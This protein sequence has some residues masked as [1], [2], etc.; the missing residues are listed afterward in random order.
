MRYNHD[1]QPLYSMCT[2]PS[3]RRAG[4]N[5]RSPQTLL[6]DVRNLGRTSAVFLLVVRDTSSQYPAK[7]PDTELKS[8][9]D[10]VIISTQT[11]RKIELYIIYDVTFYMISI[12]CMHVIFI[13]DLDIIKCLTTIQAIQGICWF[14]QNTEHLKAACQM[15]KVRLFH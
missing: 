11:P 3:W 6:A 10:W 7:Y 1:I 13:C 2:Y 5:G 9:S 14:E 8:I 4:N 15:G 12:V